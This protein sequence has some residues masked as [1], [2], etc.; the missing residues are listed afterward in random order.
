MSGGHQLINYQLFTAIRSH[1]PQSP[2]SHLIS[3]PLHQSPIC[4][5]VPPQRTP[6]R[7]PQPQNIPHHRPCPTKQK[8][9]FNLFF[10]FSFCF[11]SLSCLLKAPCQLW[12]MAVHTELGS[13]GVFFPLKGGFYSPLLLN[14]Y[15]VLGIALES[16]TQYRQ[17]STVTIYCYIFIQ[18]K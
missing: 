13:D 18:E 11:V 4:K 7:C 5:V 2:K 6:H 1:H 17:L 10:L 3:R 15:S 12:Q 14:A 9:L 16:L 8:S